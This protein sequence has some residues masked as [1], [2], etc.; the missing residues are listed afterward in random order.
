[1]VQTPVDP[2]QPTACPTLAPWTPTPAWHLIMEDAIL[3]NNRASLG[4]GLLLGAGGFLS[5]RN[6]SFVDNTASLGGG[7]YLGMLGLNAPAGRPTCSVSMAGSSMSGN[8]GGAVYSLCTGAHDL[9]D[10][11]TVQLAGGGL[12]VNSVLGMRGCKWYTFMLAPTMSFHV[13]PLC[14]TAPML[15]SGAGVC[16]PGSADFHAA[17]RVRQLGVDGYRLQWVRLRLRVVYSGC[18]QEPAI[19]LGP[20]SGH[21]CQRVLP[22]DLRVQLLPSDQSPTVHQL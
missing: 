7:M 13:L 3:T 6:A 19:L 9:E 8:T 14:A 4:G 2:Q 21:G 20:R 5:L 22:S 12:Q 1:M 16:A 18:Q 17:A 10:G 15:V 11:N